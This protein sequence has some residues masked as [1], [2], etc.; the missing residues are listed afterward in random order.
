MPKIFPDHPVV[1]ND[2]LDYYIE[3]EHFD[4][5]VSRAL[6]S[7][8][9]LGQLDNTIVVVTSDHGMPF[10]SGESTR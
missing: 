10:P 8:E 4:K 6:Q 3:I 5:M 7:L 9:K 2:I 1:R